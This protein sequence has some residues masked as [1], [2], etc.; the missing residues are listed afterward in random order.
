MCT[1]KT[2]GIGKTYVL[3]DMLC[4]ITDEI[5]GK[6][7]PVGLREKKNV[8][9]K[10]LLF[11]HCTL[12]SWTQSKPECEWKPAN[13]VREKKTPIDVVKSIENGIFHHFSRDK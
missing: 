7:D 2:F 3:F 12:V 8:S 1:N 11:Q 4:K 5:Q 6:H 10:T 9:K 13:A